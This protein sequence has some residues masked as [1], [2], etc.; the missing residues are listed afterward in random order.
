MTVG[1]IDQAQR[2]AARV[3][4]FFYLF[5]NLT[6]NFAEFFVRGN[7]IVWDSAAQTAHNIVTSDRLFRLSI[8]SDLACFAGDVAMAAAFYVLLRPVNRGVALVGSF[9]R[10]ADAAI[11]GVITLNSFI[12]LRL[13]SGV[14]YLRVFQ[15]D[16]LQALARLFL[17]VQAAGYTI[18]LVFFGI[19]SVCIGYLLFKSSYIPRPLAVLGVAAPLLLLAGCF[20][21]IVFPNV[22]NVLVPSVFMPMLVFEVVTGFWLLIKGLPSGA[23]TQGA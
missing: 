22:G 20:A 7:L 2:T 13:L 6:A 8:A 10:L 19:G 14:D 11:L 15:P 23:C 17:G 1:P 3:I 12:V 4:G 9:F 18:G 5:G 21:T 16:Q